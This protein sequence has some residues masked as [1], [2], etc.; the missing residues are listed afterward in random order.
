[1]V[2]VKTE[3]VLLHMVWLSA[4][5]SAWQRY[6]EIEEETVQKEP[7]PMRPKRGRRLSFMCSGNK[8]S[9]TEVYSLHDI[10]CK[11]FQ[12]E[13]T[14]QKTEP[15]MMM[16]PAKRFSYEMGRMKMREMMRKQMTQKARMTMM[17]SAKMKGY[18]DEGENKNKLFIALLI[19][20][21]LR[22]AK[23]Q[24][25]N[26][27]MKQ[28][29]I[30]EHRPYQMM[31]RRPNKVLVQSYQQMMQPMKKRQENRVEQMSP[32]KMCT[33][34]DPGNT[35]SMYMK[36]ALCHNYI[37]WKKGQMQELPRP[38][39]TRGQKSV[40]N[41]YGMDAARSRR[42]YNAQPMK[43]D[44]NEAETEAEEAEEDEVVYEPRMM[45]VRKMP[46]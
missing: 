18:N 33:M 23:M 25:P 10:L 8:P 22:N 35:M 42:R 2:Y 11:Y 24:P 12:S 38:K 1:M 4:L 15:M 41:S 31:P 9:H 6:G 30:P 43:R 45:R 40:M 29:M 17:N 37:Q 44:M 26:M 20:P 19:Q 28:P 46:R 16:M 39:M 14:E 34:N 5:T 21:M 13:T 3:F 32:M 7:M 36:H 27:R